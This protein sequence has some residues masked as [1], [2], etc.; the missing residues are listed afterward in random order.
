MG[1]AILLTGAP[2]SGKTTLVRRLLADLARPAD[3]FFTQE[4]RERGTR[5]SFEIITLGVG[6]IEQAVCS[7]CLVV[8]DEIGPMEILSERFRHCLVQGLATRLHSSL[9]AVVT[10][11]DR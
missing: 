1:K 3:G 10:S 5:K 9:D 2:G 7:G 4:I 11:G 6:A 8:I